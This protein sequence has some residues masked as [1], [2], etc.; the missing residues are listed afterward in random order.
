V[1]RQRK[2]GWQKP[3]K[4]EERLAS[5]R[6]LTAVI[7]RGRVVRAVTEGACALVSMSIFKKTCDLKLTL[8]CARPKQTKMHAYA[9]HGKQSF[10]VMPPGVVPAASIG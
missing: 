10:R 9:F 6:G 1:Q 5:V 4:F 7:E 8:K 3:L 2:H